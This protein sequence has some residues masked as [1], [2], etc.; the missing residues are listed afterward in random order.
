MKVY[1]LDWHGTLTT[2]GDQDAIKAFLD[3]LHERGD[4]T[5][6]HSGMLPKGTRGWFTFGNSKMLGE[7]LESLAVGAVG[8]RACFRHM[9]PKD[10]DILFDT[11]QIEEIVYSDDR[12]YDSSDTYM[13]HLTNR[14]GCP[15]C[16]S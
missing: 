4:Y 6:G 3:A 5:Y 7:Q 10:R 11:T 12:P 13:A 8:E 9:D 16:D 15:P 14:T 2:L 1:L